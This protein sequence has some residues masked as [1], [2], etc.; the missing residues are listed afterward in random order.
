MAAMS[1]HLTREDLTSFF[2]R[3]VEPQLLL[4]VDRHLA[5]CA[6]C[7]RKVF[8]RVPRIAPVTTADLEESIHLTYEGIA[9]FLDGE[10]S[11]ETRNAVEL[12]LSFCRE[13]QREAEDIREFDRGIAL[14]NQ[15]TAAEPA[16]VRLF[17]WLQAVI[18]A[19]IPGLP[20]AAVAFPILGAI[21]AAPPLFQATPSGVDSASAGASR[22]QFVL[23]QAASTLSTLSLQFYAGAALISAGIICFLVCRASSTA[24]TSRSKD[25]TNKKE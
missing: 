20:F 3:S 8:E 4:R 21:L 16:H 17:K 23:L 10:L 2:G 25:F 15:R 1:G 13:C 9:G 24:R 6:H 18:A 22:R 12:H 5:K 19:P 14:R 11:T 7:Q